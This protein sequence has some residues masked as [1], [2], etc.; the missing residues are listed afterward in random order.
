MAHYR[1]RDQLKA[2]ANTYHTTSLPGQSR[3]LLGLAEDAAPI[4]LVPPDAAEAAAPGALVLGVIIDNLW[5]D[6]IGAWLAPYFDDGHPKRRQHAVFA[7]SW[8]SK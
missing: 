6:E 8:L 7:S 1:F 4:W 5:L 2:L 3:M